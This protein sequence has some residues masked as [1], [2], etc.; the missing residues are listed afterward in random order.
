MLQSEG[1]VFQTER[2]VSIEVSRWHGW[3]ISR[4]NSS[5]SSVGGGD[6]CDDVSYNRSP[7]T[8]TYTFQTAFKSF[9]QQGCWQQG[10]KDHYPLTQVLQFLIGACSLTQGV[11]GETTSLNFD[12]NF[13]SASSSSFLLGLQGKVD[14]RE[15]IWAELDR[16]ASWEFLPLGGS[17]F[18]LRGETMV[19]SS[20]EVSNS[21]LQMF[22]TLCSSNRYLHWTWN[23]VSFLKLLSS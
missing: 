10:G 4:E 8:L 21:P 19:V 20:K 2:R 7:V 18:W 9:F 16:A 12:K 14:P 17:S 5:W 22:W 6:L 1:N 15:A 23:S 11:L 13:L 3:R